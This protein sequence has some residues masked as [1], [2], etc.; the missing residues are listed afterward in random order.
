[1][2]ISMLNIDSGADGGRGCTGVALLLLLL[3]LV[4]PLVPLLLLWLLLL[5]DLVGPSARRVTFDTLAAR[6]LLLPL[7]C[8]L[9]ERASRLLFF[10]TRLNSS[11]LL[12]GTREVQGPKRC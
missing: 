8:R 11:A 10:S 7:R 3:L 5:V 6:P 2:G 9:R 4:L 12:E 1:M